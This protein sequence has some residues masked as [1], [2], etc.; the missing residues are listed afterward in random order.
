MSLNGILWVVTLSIVLFHQHFKHNLCTEFEAVFKY[1]R[2]SKTIKL[3]SVIYQLVKNHLLLIGQGFFEV[4]LM[5]CNVAE[6]FL[7][8]WL[9]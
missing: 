6:Q 1:C 7:K 8:L 5:A 3:N 4:G 9:I 2:F